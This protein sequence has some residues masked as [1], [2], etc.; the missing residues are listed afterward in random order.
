MLAG[1]V[2]SCQMVRRKAPPNAGIEAG[3]F[4]AFTLGRCPAQIPAVVKPSTGA[5]S[6][7]PSTKEGS[8]VAIS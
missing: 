5:S 1:F 4:N 3:F 6:P 2:D 8:A 7:S